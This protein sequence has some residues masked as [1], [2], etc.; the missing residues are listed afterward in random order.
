MFILRSFV[1]HGCVRTTGVQVQPNYT[2]CLVLLYEE[3]NTGSHDKIALKS[4]NSVFQQETCRIADK[5]ETC[6]CH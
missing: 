3:K 2:L 4:K 6:K 1:S 5:K